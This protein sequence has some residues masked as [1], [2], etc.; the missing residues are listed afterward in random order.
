MIK[1]GDFVVY[2]DKK[3]STIYVGYINPCIDHHKTYDLW[4]IL[5]PIHLGGRGCIV[6][7]KDDIH[8]IEAILP[9]E[10]EGRTFK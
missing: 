2:E 5:A 3:E 6:S 7:Q 8:K 4:E 9:P 1:Q 10:T